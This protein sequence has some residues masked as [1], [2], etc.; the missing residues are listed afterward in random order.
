MAARANVPAG[1]HCECSWKSCAPPAA[2][3]A[4]ARA[5]V[6]TTLW[7]DA[8]VPASPL[9][10]LVRHAALRSLR[11]LATQGAAGRWVSPAD[12]QGVLL[13][14][15]PAA[16]APLVSETASRTSPPAGCPVHECEAESRRRAGI[17]APYLLVHLPPTR[18]RAVHSCA[19]GESLPRCL[20]GRSVY[21][22]PATPGTPRYAHPR[23]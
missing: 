18:A 8:A 10:R 20:R 12:V 16:L 19:A 4:A 22:L 21:A 23:P 3:P 17:T 7:A 11:P 1:P 9:A 2:A 6:A 13:G 5:A 14:P 15:L